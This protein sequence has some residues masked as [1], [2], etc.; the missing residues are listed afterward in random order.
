MNCLLSLADCVIELTS[1]Y[2]DEVASAAYPDYDGALHLVK[3]PSLNSLNCLPLKI[4]QLGGRR[5]FIYKASLQR[6]V[7]ITLNS[8]S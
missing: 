7:S 6:S 1:F 4:T 5:T 3:L 8:L 2:N